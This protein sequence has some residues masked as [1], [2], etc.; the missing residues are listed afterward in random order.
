MAVAF[1]VTLL[2]LAGQD[3]SARAQGGKSCADLSDQDF[4]QAGE[5]WMG[6]MLG[7]QSHEA[8]DRLMVS[9]MGSSGEEQMHEY[10]GRRVSG[11]GGGTVPAGY[12]RMMSMMAVMGGGPGPT[13]AG[14]MNGR[15]GP[16]AY[17]PGSMMGGSV[18][19]DR[20]DDDD[21]HMS[22][23]MAGGMVA[24]LLVFAGL[25]FFVVRA[26]QSPRAQ[27]TPAEIL[28]RRY[29][30]GEITQADYERRLELL[31]GG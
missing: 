20:S 12:G 31:G 3:A 10:M 4:A 24:L 2:M 13:G 9:M 22:G 15:A 5:T 7:T 30:S 18:S 25:I 11:C 17:G 26:L 6:R 19:G 1:G 21:G 16:G 28:R 8:M 29:A 27:I 14:M 23:W